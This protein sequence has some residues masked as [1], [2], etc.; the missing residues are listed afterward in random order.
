LRFANQLPIS[1][2]REGLNALRVYP[3]FVAGKTWTRPV[4]V[5][6]L[7]TSRCNSKCITCDSWKLTDHDRELTTEDF[8]RLAREIA[9]LGVPIVTIGGG[10]PTLR[11][12]L[13]EIIAA[14]KAEKRIVQLTTNGLTARENQR[15]QMYASGLDRVTFSVDSHIPA[16]YDK[17]RGV[18]GF[19]AVRENLGALLSERSQN[20]EVDT[21][22]V[23][24]VDNAETFLDTIDYLINLGVPKVNFS[25]VTTSGVN[26]LMT[27]AKDSLARIPLPLVERIVDG[28]LERKR[29]TNAISA[30]T[31]FIR[32][33]I[34]YYRQPDRVVYPCYA[35][36][37]TI[38]IFQ[39][40]SIHGCGNLPSFANVRDAPLQEIWFGTPAARN[41]VDMAEGKCPNCYLSCKIELA[42]GA[43][44]RHLP[45]FAFEKLCK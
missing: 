2:V 35:G 11:K 7:I 5:N 42:I 24:C 32:G 10:E 39:D 12:D 14:L 26:F 8:K 19:E 6:F 43:N 34:D 44:P 38:D 41:R 4:S 28:L 17:I 23:L 40:G 22:T 25:A 31:A 1:P 3:S 45:K 36:Y 16:L 37:L 13:W 27:E 20:L 9:D 33:M 18:E 21:N 30:S 15:N 29:R